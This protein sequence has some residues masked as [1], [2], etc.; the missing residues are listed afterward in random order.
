M[1]FTLIW[2][3][4]DL[5]NVSDDFSYHVADDLES[6]L[7]DKQDQIKWKDN[8]QGL[9]Q[10]VHNTFTLDGLHIAEISF[11]SMSAEYRAVCVVLPGEQYV[12]HYKTVPKKGDAQDRLLRL[13]RENSE[14]IK[15]ATQKLVDQSSS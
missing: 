12:V 1:G 8:I 6:V 14:E 3:D 11:T 13:M 10:R 15:E 2:D 4:E 9:A 7:Q 5:E